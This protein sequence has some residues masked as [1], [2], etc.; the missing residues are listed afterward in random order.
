V[1]VVQ[2]QAGSEGW[3]CTSTDTVVFFSLPY[4]YRNF[5][6]AKGRIDRLNTEYK[7]LYYHI[8]KSRSIIDQAIW[9]NLVKK[10]NFQVSAFTKRHWE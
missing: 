1:Y 8:F 6:Q 4:S 2:Y 9:R 7:D 5:E 3:N 10:K